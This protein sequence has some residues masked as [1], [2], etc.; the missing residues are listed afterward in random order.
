MGVVD[1][2]SFLL[3]AVLTTTTM[4][5]LRWMSTTLMK[6]TLRPH[7][8]YCCYPSGVYVFVLKP[9]L[10]LYS[11]NYI[12][13]YNIISNRTNVPI[14]RKLTC[15]TLFVLGDAVIGAVGSIFIWTLLGNTPVPLLPFVVVVFVQ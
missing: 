5:M 15:C 1:V 10:V 8:Y 9:V 11:E 2:A 4:M 3:I 13:N 6:M 12:E 14:S 7:Y